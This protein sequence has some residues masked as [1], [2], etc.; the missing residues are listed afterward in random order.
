MCHN[1]ERTY[2]NQRE[3]PM[4]H[5][6]YSQKSLPWQVLILIGL[7]IFHIS[8]FAEMKPKIYKVIDSV[9]D[10]SEQEIAT[11]GQFVCH[12][13]CRDEG[14]SKAAVVYSNSGSGK[15]RTPIPRKIKVA[16]EEVKKVEPPKGH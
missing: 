3:D 2:N 8:S 7:A 15:C 11:G 12:Y 1:F 16:V 6:K 9:C 4:T 13:I 10:L 5:K 14:K